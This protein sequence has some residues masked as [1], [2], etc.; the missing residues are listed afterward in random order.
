MAQDRC[1]ADD[2]GVFLTLWNA[3]Q[4]CQTPTIHVKIA[5]W[6]QKCWEHG[7]K[8]LLL[9]AFRASGKSTLAAIF[10]AW[11]LLKD[12]DSRILVLSAESLLATKMVRNIKKVIEK[13][14]LTKHLRP[15]T[16]DQWA[17]DS[18]TVKRSIV[19]RDPSVL[20][21]GLY[22]NTTG[23]RADLIICDDVEVPNTCDTPLKRESLRERLIENEFILNP[24]GTILFIGT[25]HS[26]YSIYAKAARKEI[27]E[28][29]AFLKGYKRLSI[30]VLNS[31]NAS[32]WPERYSLEKIEELRAASGSLQFLS[33]MMLTPVNIANARLDVTLLKK[34]EDGLFAQEAQ[35]ALVLSIVGQTL[36][37]AS[38]WWD[39][40]F[41]KE[42]GDGSVLAIVFTDE[43]GRQYLHRMVYIKTNPF[44][45]EDEASQQ[46]HIVAKHCDELFVPKI[47]V[48]ANGLGKFLP[49]IL[50]KVLAQNKVT[51][52]VVEKY[53][54]TSKEKRILEA[55]DVAMASQSLHVHGS[56]YETP[57]I[58]EM[59]EWR[60]GV[61]GMRDDGLDAAAGA[62][63]AEPVR[64]PKTYNNKGKSWN[65][66][67]TQ[68][69]AKTD[70][71]V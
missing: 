45:Q 21:R 5:I 20:A 67:G 26:Y 12:P 27:G 62:L 6:L 14:P 9:Q 18:F 4:N 47:Y 11:I 56:V 54:T 17:S 64:I 66:S 25:P 3:N 61:K 60:P 15:D 70:F 35:K 13:H 63:A 43:K 38:A 10:C 71:D 36:A 57:F 37:S 19:S 53:S 31:K 28:K 34:Y 68:H 32:N 2:F 39:P 30:P 23:T 50:R 42:K 40:S 52:S 69:T 55:F 29:R 41:G 1:N 22:A 49:A 48:E 7:H 33:Q 51:T 58:S 46:C 24:Q 16:P 65:G 44:S 59:V 8:R